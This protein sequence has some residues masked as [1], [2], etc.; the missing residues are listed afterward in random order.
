[1]NLQPEK[2]PSKQHLL[3]TLGILVVTALILGILTQ[4]LRLNPDQST[5]ALIGKKAHPIATAWLQGQ[6][7]LPGDKNGQLNFP[8]LEGRPVILNFWASWCVSCRSE[9]AIIQAFWQQHRNKGPLVIGIAIQDTRESAAEFARFFGKS[10]PLSLDPDGR[11]AIDYGVTGVPETFFIDPDGI[12]RRKIAG[13]V[14]RE[15]LEE[16]L[17][18]ISGAKGGNKALITPQAGE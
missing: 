3:A 4:G 7:L 18:L 11:A 15:A 10:Y 16:M 13:P 2:K 12:I 14:D 8:P 6:E 1:M 5:T 17:P 9:A